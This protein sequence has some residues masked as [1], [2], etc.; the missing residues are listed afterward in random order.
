MPFCLVVWWDKLVWARRQLQK[1]SKQST[2]SWKQLSLSQ[3]DVSLHT[4]VGGFTMEAVVSFQNECI[5]D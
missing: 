4:N 1:Q 3:S 2:E 5:V